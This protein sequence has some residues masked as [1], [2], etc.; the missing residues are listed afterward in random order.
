MQWKAGGMT[1]EYYCVPVLD[2]DLRIHTD[3]HPWCDDMSCMCHTD[4]NNFALLERWQNEG[5]ISEEDRM[6][7]FT[8]RTF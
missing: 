8:G 2:V 6:L 5:L 4:P 7:I 3:D 1:E